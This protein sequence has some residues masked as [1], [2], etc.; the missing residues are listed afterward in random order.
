MSKEYR[1]L[2]RPNFDLYFMDEYSDKISARISRR[3]KIQPPNS[4]SF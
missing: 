4:T 2:I 3:L 1:V